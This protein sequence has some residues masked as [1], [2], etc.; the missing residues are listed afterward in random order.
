MKRLP[1]LGMLA[2]A[3][4]AEAEQ[5]A[6]LHAWPDPADRDERVNSAPGAVI[7]S[8]RLSV[9][10]AAVPL[11][12]VDGGPGMKMNSPLRRKTNSVSDF[13]TKETPNL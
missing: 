12:D 10:C 13:L 1:E 11:M 2:Q 4:T 7:V 5:S 9:T 8:I 3:R 6:D